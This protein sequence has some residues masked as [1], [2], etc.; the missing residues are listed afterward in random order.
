MQGLHF[1]LTALFFIGYIRIFNGERSVSYGLRSL[2]AILQEEIA[3]RKEKDDRPK[4]V[5]RRGPHTAGF[6][7]ENELLGIPDS[8]K[9]PAG[10]QAGMVATH[11]R[12]PPK[13]GPRANTLALNTTAGKRALGGLVFPF[14]KN[15]VATEDEGEKC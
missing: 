8:P 7:G 6:A 9:K 4:K 12:T 15:W 11:P 1:L 13:R 2:E 10:K 3:G 14:R 5:S